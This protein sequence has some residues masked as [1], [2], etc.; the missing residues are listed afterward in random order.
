MG[1]RHPKLPGWVFHRFSLQRAEL[2]GYTPKFVYC[3]ND[4]LR[5][6][7]TSQSIS[8]TRRLRERLSKEFRGRSTVEESAGYGPDFRE[9]D[10]A[11]GLRSRNLQLEF[12]A[13]NCAEAR[14]PGFQKR[15]SISAT[16]F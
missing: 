6:S 1:Y 7:D 11:V 15:V 13:G 5:G 10:F 3:L 4:P 16:S 8:L 2:L 14:K 9:P 12:G